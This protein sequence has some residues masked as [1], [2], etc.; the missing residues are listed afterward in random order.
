MP[1]I[2]RCK[3]GGHQNQMNSCG[4]Y[5]IK[6]ALEVSLLVSLQS[7]PICGF[8][9]EWNPP[10]NARMQAIAVLQHFTNQELRVLSYN[11][12]SGTQLRQALCDLRYE[13]I[14]P[15]YLCRLASLPS[16]QLFTV[17]FESPMGG[18]NCGRWNFSSY[19]AD[20]EDASQQEPG[21]RSFPTFLDDAVTK[22]TE[23]NC[24]LKSD[25]DTLCVQI[26]LGKNVH[27]RGIP[28]NVYFSLSPTGQVLLTRMENAEGVFYPHVW[29]EYPEMFMSKAM[30]FPFLFLEADLER[31]VQTD[32]IPQILNRFIYLN[33]SRLDGTYGDELKE[34]H[35]SKRMERLAASLLKHPHQW[36][37]D[38]ANY[39]LIHF[40]QFDTQPNDKPQ[41]GLMTDDTTSLNQNSSGLKPVK[42]KE[43]VQPGGVPDAGT[44][45]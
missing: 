39:Y 18:L 32:T 40:G 14:Y 12:P 20:G 25:S 33:S 34:L 10:Q 13:A 4:F 41:T 8:A 43:D 1:A 15:T 6:A 19:N 29:G 2:T 9:G 23:T 30:Q 21:F 45:R 28:H 26:N 17:L 5:R 36:V 35:N 42:T 37:R 31:S 44:R 24:F 22:C 16:R 3:K 38:A 11:E 7:F 27:S